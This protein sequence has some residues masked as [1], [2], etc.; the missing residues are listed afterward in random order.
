MKRKVFTKPINLF[1]KLRVILVAEV[2]NYLKTHQIFWEIQKVNTIF[3][4]AARKSW[5][6]SFIKTHYETFITD[7][8]FQEKF[9]IS[10]YQKII[11]LWDLKITLRQDIIESAALILLSIKFQNQSEITFDCKNESSGI[12]NIT[13][14]VC[15]SFAIFKSVILKF[16]L[17]QRNLKDI[18]IKN[19]QNEDDFISICEALTATKSKL[20]SLSFC[21]CHFF[22]SFQDT[23]KKLFSVQKQI[24]EFRLDDITTSGIPKFYKNLFKILAD[25]LNKHLKKLSL[26]NIDRSHYRSDDCMK[27]LADLLS[28]ENNS[29]EALSLSENLFTKGGSQVILF[30]ILN[31]EDSK[32]KSLELNVN[33]IRTFCCKDYQVDKTEKISKNFFEIISENTTLI[34]LK[35]KSIGE[36]PLIVLEYQPDQIYFIESFSKA[37]K[38][39]N[40]LETLDYRNNHLY[41]REKFFAKFCDALIEN[42]KLKKILLCG[43]DLGKSTV[44]YGKNNDDINTKNGK[45]AKKAQPLKNIFVEL[46]LRVLYENQNLVEIDLSD[47]RLDKDSIK[48]LKEAEKNTGIKIII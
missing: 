42:Q 5:V 10:L 11:K 20:K 16:I 37:I 39:N 7:V 13:P 41:K 26:A 19:I 45:V 31:N 43:N 40:S 27:Q 35:L 6:I 12:N 18:T 2:F 15:N 34:D 25:K 17:L 48:N 46:L 24:S 33:D 36:E 32:I 29:I 3:Y 44:T 1:S 30:N 22:L 4:K 23:L 9:V 21:I 14:D 28:N 38:V 47:N 8:N